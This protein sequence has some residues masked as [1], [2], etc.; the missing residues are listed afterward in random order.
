MSKYKLS[1]NVAHLFKCVRNKKTHL[2]SPE[3][4]T[5]QWNKRETNKT[6]SMKTVNNNLHL[7]GFL[8]TLIGFILF[9]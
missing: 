5:S 3:I 2:N 4:K 9:L 1:I 7:S 8:K 6:L